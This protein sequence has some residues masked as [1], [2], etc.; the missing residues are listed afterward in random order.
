MTSEEPQEGDTDPPSS[1]RWEISFSVVLL[2]VEKGVLDEGE[3]E[4][5]NEQKINLSR[6]KTHLPGFNLLAN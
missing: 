4:G 2:V 5:Q 3:I 6:L 1:H